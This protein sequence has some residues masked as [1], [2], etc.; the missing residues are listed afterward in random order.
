[1]SDLDEEIALSNEDKSSLATRF[2]KVAHW[3]DSAFALAFVSVLSLCFVVC[4]WGA[5]TAPIPYARAP[6]DEFW[7][8]EWLSSLTAPALA[9][10]AV[11]V[12]S[13][14]IV[15]MLWSSLVISLVHT[16]A[17]TAIWVSFVSVI[18][19]LCAQ[20]VFAFVFGENLLG[21]VFL[22]AAC[23][24]GIFI[25]LARRRIEFTA[26]L[27][28]TSTHV[29]QVL[30]G[31]AV[32]GTAAVAV[33][34]VFV[35]FW[36]VTV[37][38]TQRIMA[39]G[40][41]LSLFSF[42]LVLFWGQQVI[43]NTLHTIVAGVVGR[44]YF[45]RGYATRG[46]T[47]E[48]SRTDLTVCFGSICF[49]SLLVAILESLR[50]V[51][52][53]VG[54]A[55][56]EFINCIVSILLLVLDELVQIVN[57]FAFSYTAIY[58]GNYLKSARQSFALLSDRGVNAIVNDSIAGSLLTSTAMVGGCLSALMALVLAKTL[59]LTQHSLV[60]GFH[61]YFAFLGFVCGFAVSLLLLETIQ[62]SVTT[63]FIC[64]AED[65]ERLEELR[66]DLFESLCEAY[67]D[68]SLGIAVP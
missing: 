1:M 27:L 5:A 30:P 15:S 44:W 58:G 31:I 66:P 21:A 8:Q 54:S 28:Q 32:A 22:F 64:L 29:M 45:V 41:P 46:F 25:H 24:Q 56:H 3:N 7:V 16:N 33:H 61:Y 59:D 49:G 48:A 65:P 9:A 53:I 36:V 57:R 35:S 6:H 14:S 52:N 67:P 20:A 23:M 11:L 12:V 42:F 34:L 19:L 51:L 68:A 13:C 18:V 17:V 55:D 39:I 10:L 47:L 40:G 4:A 50:S 60:S 38:M 43:Q 37:A 62:A 63:L 2:L 26:L